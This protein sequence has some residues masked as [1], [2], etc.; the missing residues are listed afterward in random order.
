VKGREVDALNIMVV[1]SFFYQ[2]DVAGMLTWQARIS[3]RFDEVD[4]LHV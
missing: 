1:S 2:D 4:G 3:Q